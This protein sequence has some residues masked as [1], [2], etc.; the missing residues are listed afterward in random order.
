MSTWW[1]EGTSF[2]RTHLKAYVNNLVWAKELRPLLCCTR[3]GKGQEGNFIIESKTIW[4]GWSFG[5]SWCSCQSAHW[6]DLQSPVLSWKQEK[7]GSV[8]L[9]D[10]GFFLDACN[11][12]EEARK[13][14]IDCDKRVVDIMLNKA[15][16][17]YYVYWMERRYFLFHTFLF[18]A[19]SLGEVLGLSGSIW[20]MSTLYTWLWTAF[21]EGA[22]TNSHLHCL[23]DDW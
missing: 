12:K 11:E 1:W 19:L 8:Y 7:M 13:L 2:Q 22:I 18:W 15:C 6:S 21:K 9:R 3:R 10:W 14:Y 16:I 4:K 5:E 23:R 17:Y 20:F